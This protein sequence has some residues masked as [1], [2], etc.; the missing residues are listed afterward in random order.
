MR[1]ED[2]AL[3][4]VDDPLDLAFDCAIC[5]SRIYE[6][7]YVISHLKGRV[8]NTSWGY[9]GIHVVFRDWIDSHYDTVHSDLRGPEVWD[10]T[11]PPR[12]EW[13]GAFDTV[14]SISTL[15][16]VA[17]D[18][19]RIIEEGFLPQVKPGGRVVVT[20]DLPGFQL[21]A[22]EETLGQQIRVPAEPL[23]PLNSPRP[24][25][26]MGLPN[27]FAVGRLVVSA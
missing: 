20:F 13:L 12:E 6:Y 8:H 24:E 9:E 2:F 18:H 17:E 3:F 16:E 1:V 27:D 21:N 14:L 25:R 4:A 5:W 7:P 10:I 15:E 22:V 23:T 19:W 11:T 26:T